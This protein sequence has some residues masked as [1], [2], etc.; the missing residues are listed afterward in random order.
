LVAA[1]L[2]L[3]KYRM[4]DQLSAAESPEADGH[5]TVILTSF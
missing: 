4:Q 3:K 2:T 1:Y 5:F